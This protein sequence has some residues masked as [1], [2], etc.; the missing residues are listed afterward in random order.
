MNKKLIPQNNMYP[1]NIR[2][3][4]RHTYYL[5]D[6][7]FEIIDFIFENLNFEMPIL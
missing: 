2:Y 5:F 1:Y 7:P 3:L 4:K 6:V